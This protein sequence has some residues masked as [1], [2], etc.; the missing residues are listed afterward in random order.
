MKSNK[1]KS[2]I[3]KILFE[4]RNPKDD[5]VLELLQD[6]E[7][8]PTLIAKTDT[9]F[10]RCRVIHDLDRI[11]N[12]HPFWGF[13]EEGSFVPDYMHTR[14]M[15]ANYR[16]IPYLYCATHPYVAVCEMRPRINAVLNLATIKAQTDLK[17]FD[18]VGF[19]SQKMSSVKK[20]LISDLAELFSKPVSEDDDTTFYIP[21]QYIAEYIKNRGYD[22]IAYRSS[23]TPEY[24]EKQSAYKKLRADES[25]GEEMR[26]RYNV[27][28]FNYQKCK[29]VSSNRIRIANTFLAYKQ[30][31]D[32]Q[33]SQYTYDPMLE[34][35]DSAM[36]RGEFS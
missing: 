5:D 19:E 36:Y 23:L 15:R 22:G 21:T 28:I 6:V 16:Y 14:D 34:L 2:F 27:V 29:A 4:N 13:D 24:Q 10:F 30:D 32:D 35:L 3:T 18:L 8:N 17:L 26:K 12:E 1:L 31:D 9:S 20:N 11:Q 33:T 7:T 25:L